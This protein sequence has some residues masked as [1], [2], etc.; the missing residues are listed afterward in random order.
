M[1]IVAPAA[2]SSRISAMI[3]A[4]VLVS[5]LPVGSSA[6]TIAGQ[7]TR[8]RAIATRWRSPPESLVGLNPRAMGESDPLERLIGTRISLGGGG[9]GVEQP[10]G[11]VL[12]DRRVLG[13]EELL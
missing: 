2:L 8:A 1:R 4:P 10:V 12:A 3:D 5:R 13:Q 11:D 7:P 6:R 9:A